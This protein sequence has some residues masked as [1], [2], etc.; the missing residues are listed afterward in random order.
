MSLLKELE[1]GCVYSSYKHVIPTG[2][3]PE[4]PKGCLWQTPSED[5]L[6]IRK[7]LISE[8]C[9]AYSHISLEHRKLRRS[10]MFVVYRMNVHIQTP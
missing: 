2:L 6:V 4:V 10:G 7:S 8:G 9:F 3:C 1:Q 5:A